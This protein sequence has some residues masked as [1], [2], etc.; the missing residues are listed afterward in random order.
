MP[1]IHDFQFFTVVCETAGT[2]HTAELELDEM[3]FGK[4]VEAIAAGQVE[5][6]KAVYEFNPAEGWSN[7]VTADVMAAAFPEQDEDGED[8][9]DY[10]AERIT[11]ALAGVETRVAA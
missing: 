10:S 4:V 6:V 3:T 11:P 7:D 5:N 9:S 1:H 8:L 2:L